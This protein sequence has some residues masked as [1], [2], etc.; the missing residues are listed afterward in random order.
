MN[1]YK[2][3]N[4]NPES[5]TNTYDAKKQMFFIG[6]NCQCNEKQVKIF[7]FEIQNISCFF[8][9]F[10]FHVFLLLIYTKVFI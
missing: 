7:Y 6:E 4:K 10:I 3:M 8:N 9:S 1:K 2:G 5:M